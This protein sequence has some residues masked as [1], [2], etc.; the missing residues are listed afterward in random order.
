MLAGG[1]VSACVAPALHVLPIPPV[2]QVAPVG[3]LAGSAGPLFE[4]LRLRPY[5]PSTEPADARAVGPAVG[6]EPAGSRPARSRPDVVSKAFIDA[7]GRWTVTIW[8]AGAV[9]SAAVLLVGLA[10]LR[11]LRATSRRVTEGPWHR[12]C[13]DLARSCGV[14]RG[15]DLLLGP[16]PGLVATWGWRRPAIVLP[17]S[18]SAWSAERMRVVLPARACARAPRRLAAADGGRSAALRLVVQPAGVVGAIPA[19]PRERAGGRRRGAGAGRS[20]HDLRDTARRT[21]E[22]GS[23]TPGGRGCRRRRWRVRHIWN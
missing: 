21:R 17:A 2:V 13:A 7:I 12:L 15:V 3:P 9:A 19:A 5:V 11:W 4:A 18:A 20:G 10:R 22:R 8:L 23:E 1:V 14:R 16:R 6:S